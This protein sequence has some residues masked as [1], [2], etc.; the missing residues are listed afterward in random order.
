MN[1]TLNC[2]NEETRNS[3]MAEVNPSPSP[4]VEFSEAEQLLHSMPLRKRLAIGQFI[5]TLPPE[6][7]HGEEFAYLLPNDSFGENI[8]E[9][10]VRAV[11]LVS[12]PSAL[13]QPPLLNHVI[14]D[15]FF[16]FLHA[17]SSFLP[18]IGVDV[19]WTL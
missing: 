7:W 14:N 9:A 11:K 3:S 15:Y 6:M 16:F 18:F 5:G 2:R 12:Q 17:W 8:T 13:K 4:V 10:D 1:W 19:R